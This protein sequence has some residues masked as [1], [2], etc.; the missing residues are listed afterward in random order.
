[1]DSRGKWQRV[2][3]K[4]L[5][6]T[7]VFTMLLSFIV[8]QQNNRLMALAGDSEATAISLSLAP[9]VTN[10]T[11]SGS[12]WVDYDALRS[13]NINE[14]YLLNAPAYF[15]W[16]DED[17]S[18]S[19]IYKFNLDNNGQF[20]I[21]PPAW[22][23]AMGKVHEFNAVWAGSTQ[24]KIK[25][26]LDDNWVTQN[27]YIKSGDAMMGGFGGGPDQAGALQWL[28][29]ENYERVLNYWLTVQPAPNGLNSHLDPSLWQQMAPLS[30]SNDLNTGLVK[31]DAIRGTVYWDWD[32]AAY[33]DVDSTFSGSD[34]PANDIQVVATIG[35]ANGNPVATYTTTTNIYGDFEIN[36]P[37]RTSIGLTYV[38]PEGDLR[39]VYVS[40][41]PPDGASTWSQF[42]KPY[43]YFSGRTTDDNS[44]LRGAVSDA[45]GYLVNYLYSVRF[46]LMPSEIIFD[47]VQYDTVSNL[48][49]PGTIVQ[50]STTMVPPGSGEYK[51]AWTDAS[52]GSVIQTSGP[53]SADQ[54]GTLPSYPLQVPSNL[55]QTTT[56]SAILIAPNGSHVNFDQFTAVVASANTPIGAEGTPYTGNVVSPGI[57]GHTYT[58]ALDPATPLPEGLSFNTSTGEITGT[59][60]DG[61]AGAYPVKFT[62]IGQGPTVNGVTPP[63]YTL[64]VEDSIYILDGNF[65]KPAMENQLIDSSVLKLVTEG[66]DSLPTN[67][68]LTTTVTDLPAA[69]T[70]SSTTNL[71]EG[72]PA[73]DA[74]TSTT[75]HD[76]QVTYTVTYPDPKDNT[77][78]ITET[79][80]QTKPFTVLEALTIAV[81]PPDGMVGVAYTA[82]APTVTNGQGPFTYQVSGLPA[83]LAFDGTTGIMSGTPTTAGT[84]DV[85]Y[86]VTDA[87]GFKATVT[88][89]VIIAAPDTTKP[90]IDPIADQTKLEGVVIDKVTVVVDDPTATIAVTGLPTGVTYNETTKEI[91]GTPDPITWGATEETKS[92]TVTVTATDPSNNVATEEFVITVQRDTDGDGIPDVTDTDDDGDG[93]PDVDDKDPGRYD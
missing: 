73:V 52:T 8:P 17:G 1:M 76:V 23:D 59:P 6:L 38:I 15:Q 41:I 90:V 36:L 78:T 16:V 84:Y 12:A 33:G 74:D 49:V 19:P 39:Y 71:V 66:Q 44:I 31:D 75:V 63:Q 87:N 48:A 9:A 53:L 21:D 46:A 92:Y 83:G 24:E 2:R 10:G 18:I 93:I 82:P 30:D 47:V 45:D 54:N 50:T 70:Y 91:S 25:I 7:L 62:V 28:P 72:T 89:Q 29:L 67:Y 56:Y 27:N 57:S 5:S 86:T 37:T 32:Y 3:G 60:A 13:I 34:V 64:S 35:D 88:E 77:K 11:I 51:I 58:Y 4:I 68:S 85:V 69:V 40:I 80:T 61:P 43:K 65:N 14:P 81:N 42:S 79:V 26:W 55:S 22:V 20:I